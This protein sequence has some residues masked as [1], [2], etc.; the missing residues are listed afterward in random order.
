[1][2][3][4]QDAPR[5]RTFENTISIPREDIE[6]DLVGVY[7]GAFK[8]LGQ[9]AALHPD[10]LVFELLKGGASQLCYDGKNFF[11]TNH[12]VNPSAGTVSNV[13]LT[14]PGDAIGWALLDTTKVSHSSSR[15][16]R[17]IWHRLRSRH[18][19]NDRCTRRTP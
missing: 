10:E 17:T 2:P 19:G 3:R 18:G 7:S 1:M 14:S 4:Y 11:A 16:E 5:N 15:S 13:D 8:M 6:D 12:P 9:D